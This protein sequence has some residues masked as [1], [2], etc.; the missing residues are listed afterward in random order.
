MKLGKILG[1]AAGLVLGGPIGGAVGYLGGSALDKKINMPSLTHLADKAGDLFNRATGQTQANQWQWDMWNEQNEYNT[2]AAQRAR[3]EAAGY[4]PM[5]MNSAG[6]SVSGNASSM[7][8]KSGSGISPFEVLNSLVNARYSM[9]QADFIAEQ[10]RKLRHDNDLNAG[11]PVKSDDNS[12]M[13]KIG[14]FLKWTGTKAGKNVIDAARDKASGIFN[15]AAVPK[16]P[17]LQVQDALLKKRTGQRL[18]LEFDLWNKR[19]K[20]L[21]NRRI[22]RIMDDIMDIR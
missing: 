4:N 5:L 1:G 15:G 16:S 6:S 9:Q 20:Q 2:P 10:T 11:L 7:S 21:S 17:A 12:F 3:L 8:A 18:N 19:M 14:R 22:S 13:G